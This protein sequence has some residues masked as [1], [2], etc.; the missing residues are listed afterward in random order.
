M[1]AFPRNYFRPPPVP[2]EIRGL[3]VEDAEQ[4]RNFYIY[5]ANRQ[6]VSDALRF[7]DITRHFHYV[8]V[9]FDEGNDWLVVEAGGEEYRINVQDVCQTG[10]MR[11]DLLR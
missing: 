1:T 4:W 2:V 11:H 6:A 3:T 8:A 9:E 5:A 10:P 7:Q